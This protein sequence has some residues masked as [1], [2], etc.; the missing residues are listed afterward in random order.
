MSF[1][2][3]SDQKTSSLSTD[4][5]S[6]QLISGYQALQQASQQLFANAHKT[7]QIYTRD[8]DPRILNQR[9]IEQ[10][11][12]D[13]V[14][15]SRYSRI[16]ILI[17]TEESLS[18]IDHRL[19]SLAQRFTSS[20]GIKLI[21]RDYFEEAFAFYLVDSKHILYRQNHQDYHA[22]RRQMPDFLVKEKSRYFD[23][24]WQES[25]PASFLRALY[26]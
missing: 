22:E 12:I 24:I 10:S 14:K 26:L 6:S 1:S 4:Q 11:V 15:R 23:K 13:L 3:T 19:V 17:Q 16:E 7:I 2:N 21:P 5:E 8:C 9:N 18:G 20:I 25:S